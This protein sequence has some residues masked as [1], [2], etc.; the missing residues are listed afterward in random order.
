MASEP[1]LAAPPVAI[2][3]RVHV[4]RSTVLSDYV[5]LTKPDVNL[6]IAITTASAFGLG[7]SAEA[8]HFPWMRLLYTLAGT[9][10]VASGAAALNQWMERLFDARMRRTARRPVAAGRVEPGRALAFGALASL[11]GI[12]Y[13]LGAVGLLPSLLAAATLVG[14]LLLYTPSKRRTPLCTLIGAVP[15]AIPPLIGWAAARG[16]IDPEAWV[17]FAIVFL[18]QFPHFMAIAWMYRDD[19]D[20][21]GY[22]VLPHGEERAPFV[23]LQTLLPLVALVFATLVPLVGQTGYS[24][25]IA[26]LVLGFAFLHYGVRFAHEKSGRTARHLLFAS[27]VYLPSLLI[28]MM[29]AMP[30]LG[31]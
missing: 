6:L 9:V 30:R 22:L 20:R 5:A 29:V 19:Y 18:W 17:L 3:P 13:L 27:I 28:L 31:G 21:A 24:Y 12:A 8:S 16:R 4:S 11:S 7:V 10:L 26:V 25:G 15:G 14:Y 1:M 23:V 2:V